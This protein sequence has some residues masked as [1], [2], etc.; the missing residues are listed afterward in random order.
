M[1]RKKKD[2]WLMTFLFKK[3]NKIMRRKSRR[4]LKMIMTLRRVKLMRRPRWMMRMIWRKKKIRRIR[5]SQN[6]E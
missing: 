4:K 6:E 1:G 5:M 2:K 3:K